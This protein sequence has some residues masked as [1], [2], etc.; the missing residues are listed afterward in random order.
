MKAMSNQRKPVDTNCKIGDIVEDEKGKLYKILGFTNSTFLILED[1]RT[2]NL[3]MSSYQFY[4]E[5]YIG[6]LDE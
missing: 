5:Q 3:V 1:L 4:Y 6:G 2:K